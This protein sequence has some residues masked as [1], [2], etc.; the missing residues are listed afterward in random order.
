L[1]ATAAFF[2]LLT[3]PAF[4]IRCFTSDPELVASGVNALRCAL[5][6]LPLAGY[7]IIGGGV[8]Q[9]LGK[10]IP[11]LLLTLSRQV[12]ILIPLVIILPFFFGLNGVWYAFPVSDAASFL[13]TW[14]LIRSVMGR[15]PRN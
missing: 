1:T 8:F 5:F 9:A 13:I 12:L 10:A 7:Q 6:C 11:A 4:F 14:V 2:V 3:F 15:L